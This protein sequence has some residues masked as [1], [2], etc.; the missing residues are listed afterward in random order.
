MSHTYPEEGVAKEL[1]SQ[2]ARS[3]PKAL[4]S[5]DGGGVHWTCTSTNAS[6]KCLVSCFAE[7]YLVSFDD[8]GELSSG[9]SRV[10]TDVIAAIAA[11][12][13]GSS[14]SEM[15]GTF[16]FVDRRLR[17]LKAIRDVTTDRCPALRGALTIEAQYG[18]PKLFVQHQG[19]EVKLFFYGEESFPR[20]SFSGEGAELFA[21]QDLGS[22]S[23]AAQ[24]I[25]LWLAKLAPPSTFAQTFAGT[26]LG[27]E[28]RYYEKGSGLE[29]EFVASWEWIIEFFEDLGSRYGVDGASDA[30]ALLAV[31]RARGYDHRLRAGQSM[32][33]LTLSRS[34]D[35]GLRSSQ[36]SLA[37]S[38]G[39]KSIRVHASLPTRKETVE[40]ETSEPSTVVLH[41]LDELCELEIDS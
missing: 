41:M 14:I 35:H 1:H 25:E 34:Q 19:R 13:H 9:R 22:N 3:L 20:I 36:A 32:S 23:E 8:G 16:A 17:H 7:E 28:A 24:M 27:T 31:L 11:W 39:G 6:R 38:F 2:L 12:L 10:R 40:F 15:Y 29:G 26:S 21:S 18:Q 37:F 30:V 33:T 4:H 5:Y